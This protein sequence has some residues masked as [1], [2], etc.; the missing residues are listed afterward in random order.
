MIGRLLAWLRKTFCRPDPPVGFGPEDDDPYT[1][2]VLREVYRTGGMVHGQV[3]DAG[4]L[5]VTYQDGTTVVVSKT[6][7]YRE[8]PEGRA[9]DGTR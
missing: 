1:L 5:R 4:D 2:W 6:E 9:T 7:V 8:F 3:L